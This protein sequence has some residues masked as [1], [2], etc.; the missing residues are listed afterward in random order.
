MTDQAESELVPRQV[1]HPEKMAARFRAIQREF[2]VLLSDRSSGAQITDRARQQYT[3]LQD[4]AI[5]LF[6]ALDVSPNRECE[7]D[8]PRTLPRPRVLIPAHERAEALFQEMHY[9]VDELFQLVHGALNRPPPTGGMS[10]VFLAT[11]PK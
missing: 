3:G 10:G 2:L 4:M 9:L 1:E 6:E 11:K 7:D 8:G 5:A